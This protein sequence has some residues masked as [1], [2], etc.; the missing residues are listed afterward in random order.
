MTGLV[1]VFGVRRPLRSLSL[2][3][4]VLLMAER[5]GEEAFAA[6]EGAVRDRAAVAISEQNDIGRPTKHLLGTV[7]HDVSNVADLYPASLDATSAV[8]GG[9]SALEQ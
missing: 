2:A 6:T 8:R 1:K 7:L 3:V 9:A 4:V 5:V